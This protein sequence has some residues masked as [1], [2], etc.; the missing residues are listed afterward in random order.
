MPVIAINDNCAKCCGKPFKK[1][2]VVF[3]KGNCVDTG[4]SYKTSLLLNPKFIWHKNEVI[5]YCDGVISVEE[6]TPSLILEPIETEPMFPHCSPAQRHGRMEE[7][8]EHYQADK[9]IWANHHG[10]K[11][12]QM[13]IKNEYDCDHEYCLTRIRE[14]LPQFFMVD[15][16]TY[17]Y[18]QTYP[19]LEALELEKRIKVGVNGNR[20]KYGTYVRV[21]LLEE[22]DH[23]KIEEEAIIIMNYLGHF[24]I[25]AKV[26][27]LMRMLIS[28][29]ECESASDRFSLLSDK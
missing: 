10:D 7:M 11:R 8:E 4:I 14:E 27:D 12:L 13:A 17:Y 19:S 26:K 15:H 9:I 5:C 1:C 16:T 21:C 2:K 3:R 6:V 29:S 22:H 24:E 23:M 25:M 28:E 18:K 20:N